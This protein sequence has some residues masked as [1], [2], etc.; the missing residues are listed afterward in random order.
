VRNAAADVGR[1]GG[2][3]GDWRLRDDSAGSGCAQ[4]RVPERRDWAAAASGEGQADGSA[5]PGESSAAVR[6]DGIMRILSAAYRR[7]HQLNLS[8]RLYDGI[9]K[10]NPVH[11]AVMDGFAL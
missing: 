4:L 6:A 2:V 7:H 8:L 1:S 3:A 5:A 9:R 10:L 11:R